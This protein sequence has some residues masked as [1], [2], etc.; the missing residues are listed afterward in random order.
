L[1]EGQILLSKELYEI[2]DKLQVIHSMQADLDIASIYK[3]RTAGGY[4]HVLPN[5][6]NDPSEIDLEILFNTVLVEKDKVL[7]ILNN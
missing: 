5:R 7:D 4:L 1:D 2:E 6:D 3:E